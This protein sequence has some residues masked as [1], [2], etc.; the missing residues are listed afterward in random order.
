MLSAD[1][2]ESY[3]QQLRQLLREQRRRE[4]APHERFNAAAGDDEQPSKS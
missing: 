2:V 3:G 4:L 1:S